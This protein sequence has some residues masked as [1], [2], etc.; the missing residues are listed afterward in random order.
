[1]QLDTHHPLLYPAKKGDPNTQRHT[2]THTLPPHPTS[3]L[4][5]HP[6]HQT[7]QT[8]KD[9]STTSTYKQNKLHNTP[10]A[11]WRP[12]LDTPLT[13]TTHRQGS[14][15]TNNMH[16]GPHTPPRI[17]PPRRHLFTYTPHTHTY[18]PHTPKNRLKE[19]KFFFFKWS[20]FMYLSQERTFIR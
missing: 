2:P 11:T 10:P 20:K 14:T 9:I 13:F 1:M 17:H 4:H 18:S 8:E 6:Y 3:D 12:F 16:A 5:T 15:H 7:H 19:T